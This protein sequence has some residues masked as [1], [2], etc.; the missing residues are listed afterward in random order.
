MLA[1]GPLLSR[2]PLHLAAAEAAALA[3]HLPSPSRERSMVV[4]CCRAGRHR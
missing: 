3:E 4:R 2:M 1:E